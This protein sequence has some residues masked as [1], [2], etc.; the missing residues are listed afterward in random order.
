M[1]RPTGDVNVPEEGEVRDLEEA[2]QRLEA[3]FD[4]IWR[5]SQNNAHLI[6]ARHRAF[7]AQD[8]SRWVKLIC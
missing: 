6:M 4:E 5:R 3:N 2:K 8:P 1:F 7:G